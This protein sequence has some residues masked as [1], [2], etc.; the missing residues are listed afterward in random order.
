MVKYTLWFAD[1]I[2][3][4]NRTH[5][6]LVELVRLFSQFLFFGNLSSEHQCFCE[7]GSGFLLIFAC[8]RKTPDCYKFTHELQGFL[9]YLHPNKVVTAFLKENAATFFCINFCEV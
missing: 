7:V 9:Y 1:E 3:L 8:A 4:S 5:H 6:F 2:L